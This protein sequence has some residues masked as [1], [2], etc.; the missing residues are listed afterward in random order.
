MI[1]L[2]PL[3]KLTPSHSSSS[4]QV[5]HPLELSVARVEPIVLF[6]HRTLRWRGP[7]AAARPES[8][9]NGA[10]AVGGSA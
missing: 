8:L 10:A 7:P 6:V 5:G 1:A 4:L 9:A 3:A 2:L